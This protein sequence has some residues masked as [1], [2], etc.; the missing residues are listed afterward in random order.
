MNGNLDNAGT[1]TLNTAAQVNVLNN[2]T[3]GTINLN[4]NNL[5]VTKD[6]TNANFGTGNSFDKRSGLSGAGQVVASGDV[7]QVLSGNVAG[8]S[9]AAPTMTF[10]NVHVGD[11]VSQTYSIGNG[12]TAGPVLRGAVQ[13]NVNG[14]NITDGRLSGSGVT[15]GNY[16]PLATGANTGPLTV[17]FNATSAGALSGQAVHIAN[18][19]GNVGEQT[20]S[21]VSS[22]AYNLAA[23][24]ATPTPV[25]IANQRVGGTASQVLTVSNTKAAGAYTEGLNATFAANTGNATNNGGAINLLAGQGT[26]TAMGVG[27]NTGSAGH[28]AGT[29]TLNYVSDGTGTSGLGT[30]NVGSQTINVSGDVYRLAQGSTTPSPIVF[31][32]RHEGDAAS[33]VLTVQNT[34]AA[35]GYSEKLNA[36]FG[37]TTGTSTHNGGSINLLAAGGS[38][39]SAMA[40]G[41]D[42]SSA[43]A[44]SGSVTV[45][46]VSDGTGTSNLGTIGAGNQ[47]V[48][49]SGDVYR[50]AS[51]NTL[52]AVSF[53]NVHV[54]DTVQQA[55]NITNTAAADGY[56]EKLNASF[57]ASSDARI[58][59][60]GSV[61]Q[62]AAG[63][64]NNSSM[65]VGLN[66]S[67]A[68]TVNGTQVVKFASDGSG[69]SG[70]GITAL[71][72]QTIGVSGDIT[73]T[74]NVYRLASASAATPNP[75]NFGN[76]RIGATA[77][78]AVS[79]SNTATND[80]FSEKL[81][82][83]ISTNG[84]P[85]TASGAFNLLGPQ[86][87]NG[88]S[89]HVGMD[90]ST[91][92]AK[93]GSATIALVSDGTGTS[94]LGTTTLASQTVDVTGA[95]YRLANPTL[96]TSSVTVAA[97]VGDSVSANQAVSITNT[98]PDIYTEGLK[99]NVA[100]TSGNAQSNGGGIANLA[101][102]G[103]DN[104]AILVG[105]GSTATAGTTTGQVNLNLTSTGAGT[106]GAADLS[107]GTV[108][109][110][111]VG[112]VYQQAVALVNTAAVDFGIVHVGDTVAQKNVSVTNSAPTAGLN[113]V[114][115]GS[116]STSGAFSASGNLGTGLAAGVSNAPGSLTVGLNTASAGLFS[117]NAVLALASS[118]ADMA[119]LALTDQTVALKGQVNNYAKAD[120]QK[121][122]GVGSLSRSG[123]TITLNLGTLLQGSGT[124][125]AMLEVLN[126]VAGLSDLLK[127][128]FDLTGANDFTFSGFNDFS[129]LAAGDAYAGL[130]VSLDTATLGLLTDQITLHGIGY[131]SSGYSDT[132]DVFLV[133]TADVVAS[134]GAVPEPRTLAL[135]GIALLGLV[136]ARRRSSTLH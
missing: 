23:G 98:S 126:N 3:G 115:K 5:T 1:V 41:I 17:T 103:T 124:V 76:V 33:Q 71:A 28:S 108:V 13:T 44:K 59:T 106:T 111:V 113:D 84:A 96:N 66:T 68:G 31:A 58:T 16:A 72:S 62:L 42:T 100:G 128:S 57:G 67:A 21:I 120:M 132:Q 122:G 123:T 105:L 12:G 83:S 117:A 53:G 119:D 95:V 40:V 36:T 88:T 70:L 74:G 94:N 37:S 18:N 89:L 87:T 47:T 10:G 26:S 51:A 15:A 20:L 93:S 52:A 50:L 73:T 9:G 60:S 127:G 30:T 14:G 77:D 107:V 69:T 55:L 49:V 79:I 134:G 56:S 91:A 118:N 6:Y 97:R 38:N 135:L 133:L 25:T 2:N 116:I 34:A 48:S 86:S 110:N 64:S 75:V 45:N 85:V 27:V 78:Q 39:S 81:N 46:Y 99:V 43:G 101:A 114:L 54:G 11:V 90:T 121:T 22:A 19:F 112:K 104:S 92:G 4:A 109:V 129:G 61:S 131:N 136:L 80:G 24:S 63:A 65:I 29:V 125:D 7:T 102:K 130:D 32:N 82:A 35:D 8:G